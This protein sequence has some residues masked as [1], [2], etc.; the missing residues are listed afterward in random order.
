MVSYF[1]AGAELPH[2]IHYCGHKPWSE[3]FAP[4]LRFYW[5]YRAM[6]PFAGAD[7]GE[8]LRA[9]DRMTG[10][11]RFLQGLASLLS[12]GA[13]P[14]RKRRVQRFNRIR[15]ARWFAEMQ[16]LEGASAGEGGG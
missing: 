5:H 10:R 9:A 3:D 14:R 2:V 4:A 16:D 11:D 12:A 13:P 6:T 1:A 15:Y 8:L 7:P